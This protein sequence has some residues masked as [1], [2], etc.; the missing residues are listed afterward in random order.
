V[1]GLCQMLAPI[2][3]FTADEAWEFIPGKPTGSVHE[4]K[5]GGNIFS[6]SQEESDLWPK[7]FKL[8]RSV[9]A[10]LE[11]A[12]EKKEIGKS[13]DAKAEIVGQT[14]ED[15][16]AAR[17]LE[18]FRE[19]VNVS[20]IKIE[21][22]FPIVDADTELQKMPKGGSG[23]MNV[24]LTG[25]I[26]ISRADGQKCERCWHCETDIGRNAEHPTICGRCVEAVEQFKRQD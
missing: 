8:R 9:L 15:H 11:I 14:D 17:H 25:S 12:R 24:V 22:K 19:L 16:A 2:L 7:L 10:S 1:S 3:A 21:A 23:T 6:I 4:S 20:Q 18:V 5:L 26:T 13:L